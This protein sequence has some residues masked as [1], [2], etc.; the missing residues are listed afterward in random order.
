MI[1]LRN[2]ARD[3]S[4]CF[5]WLLESLDMKMKFL[6]HVSTR[7]RNARTSAC[8]MIYIYMNKIQFSPNVSNSIAQNCGKILID[9]YTTRNSS[10]KTRLR[11]HGL[12]YK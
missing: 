2:H 4:K 6:E 11:I 9:K 7:L 3:H 1:L 5:D 10:N 12:P 8:V